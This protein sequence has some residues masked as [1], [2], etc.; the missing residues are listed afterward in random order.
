MERKVEIKD[1]E[2]KQHFLLLA[3]NLVGIHVDYVTVDLINS[4]LEKL[5][6]KKGNMDM[7][8]AATIKSVHSTKWDIYFNLPHSKK[9]KK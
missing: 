1:Y 4:T 3:L 5:A 2:D 9:T 6:E 8:D 7:M